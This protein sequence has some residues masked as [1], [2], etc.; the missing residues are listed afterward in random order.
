[1]E[2]F[3]SAL[4]W[5]YI[6]ETR[7]QLWNR[8]AFLLQFQ[9]PCKED[10]QVFSWDHLLTK[11]DMQIRSRWL[12]LLDRLH[13]YLLRVKLECYQVWGLDEQFSAGA[14]SW[15]PVVFVW[16]LL[17]LYAQ[18]ISFAWVCSC[19]DLHQ[20]QVPWLH[21][22]WQGLLKVRLFLLYSDALFLWGYLFLTSLKLPLFLTV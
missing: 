17:Q 11:I 2:H 10:C 15:Q 22:S 8:N 7:Y 14:Y 21:N 12:L 5:R 3:Q 13:Y 18:R 9:E 20:S 4:Y 19:I 16:Q 1:M 6:Q